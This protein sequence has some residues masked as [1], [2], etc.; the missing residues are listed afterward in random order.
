MKTVSKP[1]CGN[2]SGRL[3]KPALGRVTPRLPKSSRLYSAPA[4]ISLKPARVIPAVEREPVVERSANNGSRG[5]TLQLYLREIGQVKLLTPQEEID[6]AARR[7]STQRP[8]G[9]AKVK[10]AVHKKEPGKSAQ[11]VQ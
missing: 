3:A 4:T 10:Q 2:R 1:N 7:Q 9:V 5:D 6:L 8:V 11:P